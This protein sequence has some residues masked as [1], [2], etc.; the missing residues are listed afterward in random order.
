MR[1]L[2]AYVAAAVVFFGLDFV[3]LGLVAKSTYRSWI[4]HLM[5]DEIHAVAA[6]LFYLVYVVGL[7]IFAVA[8]ALK[9]SAWQTAALY[10]ALFGFFAYG[11]YDLT[12]YATLKDWPFAMVVVDMAWGTALSAVAAIVGYAAARQFG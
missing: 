2:V 4:G 5:R 10:G 9:D 11:T 6:I 3:W 8:P 12:N 7:V 1:H